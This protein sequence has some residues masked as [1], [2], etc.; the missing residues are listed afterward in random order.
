MVSPWYK[1]ENW[2]S[3]CR[4]YLPALMYIKVFIPLYID[5]GFYCDE[6]FRNDASLASSFESTESSIRTR[7][8][9]WGRIFLNVVRRLRLERTPPP[10]FTPNTPTYWEIIHW[11]A[12]GSCSH[13]KPHTR[14]VYT[15]MPVSHSSAFSNYTRKV[16]HFQRRWKLRILQLINS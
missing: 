3:A 14:I 2:A 4:M 9:R 5:L 13:A 11:R 10:R 7:W 15:G 12:C 1:D 16:F 8:Q 6:L